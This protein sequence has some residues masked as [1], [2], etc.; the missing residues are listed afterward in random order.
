MNKD[1][2]KQLTVLYVEDKNEIRNF[3]SNI[4]STFLKK[5]IVC[6]NGE[7][8]LKSFK[9]NPDIDLIITDINMPKMNG[10]EMVKRINQINPEIPAITTTAHTDSSFFKDSIDLGIT[11]YCLKPL[12][13]YVLI[14]NITKILE[15]KVLK[16]YIKSNNIDFKNKT[17]VLEILNK[18]DSLMAIITKEKQYFSNEIFSNTFREFDINLKESLIDIDSYSI[19]SKDFNTYS[20]YEI[21]SRINRENILVKLKVD[22]SNK[23]FKLN[24]SEL[25]DE[26]FLISLIDITNLNEKSNLFEYKHNHDLTTGLYNLNKFHKIFSIEF[27]RVRR[28]RK[29]LAIIK[30]DIEN[31]DEN[32]SIYEDLLN[33]IAELINKNLRVHDVNFKA[34]NSSFLMLLPETNLDGALNVAYKLEGLLNNM[35]E[36]KGISKKSCFGVVELNNDD[37]EELFLQRVNS[38]L[39]KSLKGDEERVSYF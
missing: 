22:D 26:C 7:E 4:L 8:G 16:E 14:K 11:S 35:L 12:D 36:N 1:F 19:D 34:E 30:L 24:V 28:Y 13:L 2:L 15:H 5:L 38:A 6:S 20:W 27:Q 18:Q 9:E 3:T 29:D 33:D 32:S 39:N 10:L 25:K 17:D 31:I 23:I 37:N 21:I